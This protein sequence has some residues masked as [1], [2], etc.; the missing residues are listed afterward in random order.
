MVE[1][2][3]EK[4]R[5][6]PAKRRLPLWLKLA[7]TLFVAVH[8]TL[9]WRYYGPLAFLWTCDVAVLTLLAAI[10]LESRLLVSIEAIAVLVPLGLWAVD[11]AFRLARG[12]GHYLLGF[13]GY[14]F[15]PRVPWQI[16]MLST[17][18]VWLPILVFYL[19]L[20][21][22]Y[23]R[24][25]FWIQ[26]AIVV[27]LLLTCRAISPPPPASPGHPAVNINWVYGASDETPQHMMPSIAYLVLM[28][29]V[30][31]LVVYLPSH[32]VLSAMFTTAPGRPE[33]SVALPS[34]LTI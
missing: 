7:Y 26:C 8:V 34:V 25:A 24:R 17:F 19:L 30:Y 21:L 22:G 5:S 11:L 12:R 14:M 9:N 29:A 2:P 4:L 33:E 1:R 27:V 23:D 3:P 28:I 31:Q 32:L 6:Q 16:R 15:D 10:W 20:R 18:H 13:A